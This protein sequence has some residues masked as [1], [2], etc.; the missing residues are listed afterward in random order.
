MSEHLLPFERIS[1]HGPERPARLH[2]NGWAG[3]TTHAVTVLAETPKRYR[4]RFEEDAY[5]YR[6]GEIRLVPKRS[7]TFDAEPR[8]ALAQAGADAPGEKL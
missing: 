3:H 4:V 5:R 1:F 6:K 2:L 7:V 8:S